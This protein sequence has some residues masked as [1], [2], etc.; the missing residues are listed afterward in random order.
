MQIRAPAHALT[1]DRAAIAFSVRTLAGQSAP[2]T[3]RYAG[4]PTIAAVVND[5][6]PRNLSG[7]YGG[8]DTGRTPLTVTGRGMRDQVIGLQYVAV[9]A[10]GAAPSVGTQ[11]T[12]TTH[13]DTRLT[14]QTV[15]QNPALVAVQPCTVTGCTPAGTT[16]RFWIYPPGAPTVSSLSP[17]E[18]PAAGGTA[19][20]VGGQNLGCP[21]SVQFGAAPATKVTPVQ[22]RARLRL[23][24]RGD[25]RRTAGHGGHLGPG[26][27]HDPRERLHRRPPDDDRAVRIPLSAGRRA[28]SAVGACDLADHGVHPLWVYADRVAK[29]IQVRDVPDDVHARLTARAAEQRRSLSELIRAEIVQVARR[30][31][32]AEMLE[33]LSDRPLTELPETPADALGRERPRD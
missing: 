21:L 18:G 32:M 22:A 29:T 17:A 1:A 4:R 30:P 9:T 25:R 19:T 31:T 15:A 14:A 10:G 5:A 33:R 12:F 28:T 2:R 8:P 20:L 24:G 26:D 3:V 27:G 16:N 11:Y 7:L 23:D 6:N 13:G